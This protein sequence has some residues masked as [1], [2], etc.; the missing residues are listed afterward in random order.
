MSFQRPIFNKG[1]FGRANVSVCNLWTDS[2]EVVAQNTEGIA[3]ATQQLV[4]GRIEESWL[5]RLTEA[6]QIGPYR[7]KYR[8]EPF[9]IDLSNNLAVATNLQPGTFGST[10][11]TEHHHY[12]FNI[13]E[14]RN[15]ADKLDGSLLNLGTSA[16]PVGSTYIGND[17]WTLAGLQGYVHL[18]LEYD[19]QGKTLYWFDC[20]NPIECEQ[21]PQEPPPGGGE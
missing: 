9:T 18:H 6:V 8:F 10:L 7:W 21:I 19:A 3:W 4:R 1:L 5:A 15:T 16:G 14:L 11:D 20:P 2:A 12:A 13:R 17:Q